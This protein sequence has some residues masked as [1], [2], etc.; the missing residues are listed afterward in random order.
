MVS[1]SDKKQLRNEFLWSVENITEEEGQPYFIMNG[2]GK[3]VLDR[4]RLLTEV[5]DAVDFQL[6]EQPLNSASVYLSGCMG[7]GKTSDLIL[8]AKYLKTKGYNIYFFTS[9]D[10]IPDGIGT[11]LT[12]YAQQ[13]KE[14]KIAVIVDEVAT[15]PNSHLF[16]YLLKG[17]LPNM[18]TIGAAVP[19]FNRTGGTGAFRKVLR[20]SDLVLKASDEDVCGLIKHWKTKRVATDEMVD[21]VSEFL[22]GHCGGHVYPVLAFMEYFF[23]NSEATKHLTSEQEFRR[24]FFSADFAKS[25]VYRGVC[26][27]CFD[28]A[29][30]LEAESA[31]T[32]ARVL[33]G[34]EEAND[35][36]TLCR[37]GWWD[38]KKNDVLSALLMNEC[39]RNVKLLSTKKMF[40]DKS[41]GQL[42]NL[43][44]LI[45]EGLNSMEPHE[46]TSDTSPS[47]WPVENALTFNWARRV[48]SI[49]SNVHLEFQKSYGHKLMDVYVNGVVDAGVEVLRNATQTAND[50]ATEQSQ[51]VNKHARRFT[52]RQYQVDRFA[53]LNFSMDGRKEII[54]PKN[55]AYHDKMYTY[56]HSTNRLYRGNNVI[57]MHAVSKIASRPYC[58]VAQRLSGPAAASVRHL[59]IVPVSH[60]GVLRGLTRLLKK[61]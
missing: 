12:T 18:L 3:Y 13:N 44:T 59:L 46:L 61:L 4:K 6:K 57:R 14:Q 49:F 47:G 58:T 39:L 41:C 37:L 11:E 51:D 29:L 27:R 43:E 42:E 9:A 45:I 26:N 35:I 56:Q 53:L 40:L 48:M 32:I 23:T 5:S 17:K 15:K 55:E 1:C 22:L 31:Q 36:G 20:T 54:L 21:H 7:M 38:V 30:T 52:E 28:D 16:V 60:S 24:Y 10:K 25:D 33:S 8:I 34:R 19:M 2:F 50:D